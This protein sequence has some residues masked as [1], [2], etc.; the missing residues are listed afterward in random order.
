M[1]HKSGFVNIIGSPNVGKSTLM[2]QLV[3][4][5][6]SI[7][8][9]KM[10][11][12]RH[13]IMGMV[14]DKD[15]QIVFS[16]TPGIIDPAYRLHENMMK[17]V[18][19]ALKDADV[20]LM[21]TDIYEDPEKMQDRLDQINQLNVPTLLL[22]NKMDLSNQKSVEI[23]VDLWKSKLPKSQILPI[24]ALHNMSIQFI[25]PKILEWLPEN[26]PYFDKDQLTNKNMRF[27]VSEIVRE[28]ILMIYQ[29]EVPYSCEVTV[30]EYKEDDK[31]VRIR[32]NI[33]VSRTSQKSIVIGHQGKKIK[34]LGIES[35]IDIES[36]I[37]KKV[38]L[39]LFVKV[40]KDWR[41]KEGK[42]KK[43]GY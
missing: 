10:Q 34:K 27:F 31:I 28:K 3:G 32:A 29:K 38:H 37:G 8:T 36:F 2:N 16:D 13:R 43:Y 4:E 15:Y 21:V 39:E 5:K 23:M 25:L 42:L 26:P 1:S 41:D 11:T 24:S 7:I 33:M 30:E 14:N 40:D 19:E 20:I 17:F 35:R 6:L 9:S 22:L 12:T 18:S